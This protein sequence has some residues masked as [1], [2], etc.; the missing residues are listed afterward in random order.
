MALEL[1]PDYISV[2]DLIALHGYEWVGARVR[3]ARLKA[4]ISIREAAESA[5]VS[6]NTLVRLERGEAVH[7]SSL[8]QI[9]W[10]LKLTPR[11]LQ[12]IGSQDSILAVDRASEAKWFDMRSFVTWTVSESIPADVV[13]AADSNS[14]F[15][16]FYH[17]RHM[18]ERAGFQPFF[19]RL[20]S[21]TE[22]RFHR[23]EELIYV[24]KGEVRVEV[25][26]AAVT[27]GPNDALL[28]H[29]TE[30]HCYIPLSSEAPEIFCI[31]FS[32]G[33]EDHFPD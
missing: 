1:S 27:L 26:D 20:L 9:L 33:K 14:T 2:R 15:L 31:I 4:G 3:A 28:F 17:L 7:N 5:Q 32:T 30:P 8:E 25:G 18:R 11:R 21:A 29:A 13:A 23:G 6:K 24:L 16:P 19:I 10:G 22:K 12:S